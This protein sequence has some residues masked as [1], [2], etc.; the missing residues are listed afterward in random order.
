MKGYKRSWIILLIVLMAF[1]FAS[2]GA[3]TIEIP[4][5]DGSVV[6]VETKGMSGEQVQ[7]MEQVA[8]GEADMMSLMQSGLFTPEELTDMGLSL[9]G[10]RMNPEGMGGKMQDFSSIDINDLNLD[11][12]SDE[13][14]D[15]VKSLIAGEKTMQEIMSEGLLSQEQLAGIGLMGG[16]RPGNAGGGQG[17]PGGN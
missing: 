11:G 2:C 9:G 1:I 7:L 15:A 6:E 13:Q 17:G 4:L 12:L 16:Q 10:G 5:M 14:I 3:K 8:S